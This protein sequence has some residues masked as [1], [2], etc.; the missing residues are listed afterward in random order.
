M[1][2]D[3]VTNVHKVLQDNMSTILVDLSEVTALYLLAKREAT[4]TSHF[5]ARRQ[6]PQ[7]PPSLSLADRSLSLE[8]DL[9]R[10]HGI[11]LDLTQFK[12]NK[13]I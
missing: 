8:R 7:A 12:N 6:E 5:T 11:E 10:M 2:K 1:D 9:Q 3:L 13:M 4:D